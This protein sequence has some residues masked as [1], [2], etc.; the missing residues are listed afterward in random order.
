MLHPSQRPRPYLVLLGLLVALAS[1]ATALG[2]P[3]RPC[4]ATRG[5]SPAA[6]CA[7]ARLFAPNSV[8]NAA[9]APGAAIDPTS[10]A[11]VAGL[12]SEVAKEERLGWGPWI[13]TTRSS[14]IYRVGAHVRRVRVRL[15]NPTASW[16]APLQRS[17]K[18]VPIP[19][20]AVPAVGPDAHMTIWQPATDNLWEFF[21]TRKLADGWH[22]AWGGAIQHVSRS[23]GYYT[24]HSWPGAQSFWGATATS[25][26]VAAG[27]ITIAELLRGHI[28]HA[29]AVDLPY[30]RAGIYSW[31]AQR[32]DG[33]GVGSDAIPEGAHLRL[34]P[35]LDLSRLNLPPLVRMMA[36]AVQRYG[37]VVRDQTH[38]AVG[39]FIEDPRPSGSIP[40]FYGSNGLPSPTGFFEGRYPGPL[41]ASFPW[42]SLQVL[43]M[44]L[45]AN[46]G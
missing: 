37:M 32:T 3:R 14:P 42:S 21:E 40:L 1:P 13:D 27:T 28:D 41:L 19:A 2:Q 30:P 45:H 33:T 38:H 18:A 12:V 9:L 4:T 16:R 8:W 22:A 25:L 15:D 35:R 36:V 24:N 39:F 7:P 34:D 20:N 6:R 17:F 5:P 44:H 31:P 26:P 11:L 29:L 43:K 10:P 23:P 46:A